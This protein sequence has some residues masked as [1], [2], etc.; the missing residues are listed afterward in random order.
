MRG[1]FLHPAPCTMEPTMLFRF[2]LIG[3]ALALIYR[4]IRDVLRAVLSPFR[5]HDPGVR[6]KGKRPPLNLDESQ[7]QDAEFQDIE[8]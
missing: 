1:L 6:G 8:T 3:L 5:Q 2:F 7:I 4:M